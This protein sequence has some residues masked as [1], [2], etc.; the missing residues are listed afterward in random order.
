M[1]TRGREIL[2]SVSDFSGQLHQPDLGINGLTGEGRARGADHGWELRFE[3]ALAVTASSVIS[4]KSGFYHTGTST[5]AAEFD[6]LEIA[7]DVLSVLWPSHSLAIPVKGVGKVSGTTARPEFSARISSSAGDLNAVGYYDRAQNLVNLKG[8]LF[9]FSLAG[10]M[11]KPVPL[12]NMTGGFAL[13][14]QRPAPEA[15]SDPGRGWSRRHLLAHLQLLDFSY[16]GVNSFPGIAEV[17]LA[18]DAWTMVVLSEFPGTNFTAS[19]S[20][21]TLEPRPLTVRAVMR[22]LNPRRLRPGWPEGRL[23]GVLKIDGQGTSLPTFRGRV[24]AELDP[25][26]LLGYTIA[27]ANLRADVAAGRINFVNS[28]V[29]AEGLSVRGGGFVNVVSREVPF[30]FDLDAQARNDGL[31]RKLSRGAVDA[32]GAVARINLSGARN[33]WRARGSG[34]AEALKTAK[35]E[36]GAASVQLDLA[37]RAGR[38]EGM[39]D[40]RA[41]RVT[42][43]GAT[44]DV[45]ALNKVKPTGLVKRILAI[46]SATSLQLTFKLEGRIASSEIV[47]DPASND[48]LIT[49]H[50]TPA[51]RPSSSEERKQPNSHIGLESHRKQYEL[52]VI[53]LDAGHGGKD[54]GTIGVTGVKEKDVALGIVLKLGKL[55]EKNLKDVKVVYTR[56]TDTFVELDRRGQIANQANGKLFISVHCNAMPRKPSPRRGFEVYLLR[57]GRTDEA[58]AIAERENSVIELEEGFEQRYQKLT[59][60]NFILVTMAQSAHM[61]ASERF[62]EL[63]TREL[64]RHLTTPNNG[65]LQAGFLVLVGASMPNVLIET[66]YL[67]NRE[68]ERFLNSQA[69]QQQYAEAIFKAIKLYKEEYDKLL[70]EGRA[71][72]TK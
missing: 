19:I 43:P 52:D 25:G 60:E 23:A 16:P 8:D 70:Q 15:P 9:D 24:Q 69:G 11:V 58:I 28:A 49:I 50:E 72:G 29:A 55:I 65:V 3:N 40:L 14:Y 38:I 68:D 42:I 41:E 32:P 66:A 10:F 4:L 33:S 48:L 61:K 7:P 30:N 1:S 47:R 22:D 71:F 64:D 27:A 26:V 59:D 57:P 63:V 51:E 39:V 45:A 31:I 17:E 46:Q 34:S 18:D 5:V 56:K 36:T 21:S 35:A 54:P 20:A 6:R 53:V 12:E 62:A 2:F 44:A 37:S 13:T 67:S